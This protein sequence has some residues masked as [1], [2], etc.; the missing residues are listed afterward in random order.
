MA[1][2]PRTR[3]AGGRAPPA[4]RSGC[5]ATGCGGAPSTWPGAAGAPVCWPGGPERP[6]ERAS[7]GAAVAGSV[8][9][10][11]RWYTVAGVGC[12]GHDGRPSSATARP[13]V[14]WS[15]PSAPRARLPASV[16]APRRAH[17]GPDDPR[18]QGDALQPR[19]TR[20]R[21][22]D[23]RW[24][25]WPRAGR[26]GVSASDD[27]GGRLR[28]YSPDS[29]VAPKGPAY[30]RCGSPTTVATTMSPTWPGP[31]WPRPTRTAA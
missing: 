25:R 21:G 1:G 13:A 30:R 17:R 3:R 24:R 15:R 6:R 27:G 16:R 2:A 31:R 26:G 5:R 12:R 14:R 10:R 23:G 7:S 22:D 4:R 18:Y 28:G 9:R 8:L 29:P 19:G 11:S 20:R